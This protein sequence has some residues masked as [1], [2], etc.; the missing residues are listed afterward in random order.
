VATITLFPLDRIFHARNSTCHYIFRNLD[1]EP[2]RVPVSS[3]GFPVNRFAVVVGVL[4]AAFIFSC[5]SSSLTGLDIDNSYDPNK[6]YAWVYDDCG[7]S[8][9]VNWRYSPNHPGDVTKLVFDSVTVPAVRM[10][11]YVTKTDTALVTLKVGVALN[12]SAGRWELKERQAETIKADYYEVIYPILCPGIVAPK[13][14]TQP[15][16][17]TVDD[18]GLAVFHVEATD[19]TPAKSGYDYYGYYDSYDYNT[20]TWYVNGTEY[21]YAGPSF[22]YLAAYPG[23]HNAKVKVVV[24]NGYAKVT[25]RTVTLTVNATP[26]DLINL[27]T[28]LAYDFWYT[29]FGGGYYQVDT[30][31]A[32]ADSAWVKASVR[33]TGVTYQWYRN[34][35]LITGAGASLLSLGIPR[36]SD[37]GTVVKCV[38]TNPRGKDSATTVVRVKMPPWGTLTGFYAAPVNTS[39][40]SLLDFDTTSSYI[41]NSPGASVTASQERLD[42][43]VAQVGT[44]NFRLLT[45]KFARQL[46]VSS[47]SALDTA[48]LSGLK[49]VVTAVAP[50]TQEMAKALYDQGPAVDSVAINSGGSIRGNS[51]NRLILK[52]RA[53]R[54]VILQAGSNFLG[55][56][57]SPIYYFTG[58]SK[59]TI[60]D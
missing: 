40:G 3:E 53:G 26:P 44:G 38:I 57:S 56:S 22:A 30:L 7:D 31:T 48:R 24:N 12:V 19:G 4:L 34:G 16:N 18:G 32:G 17:V 58:T 37:S 9:R 13:I 29:Y 8:L 60:F 11:Q 43:V 10:R 52:T 15:E 2:I 42:L 23:D 14:T 1:A 49:M 47:V 45:P 28:V 39:Y 6:P 55:T 50:A 33:G 21:P 25:S 51:S 46:N 41:S 54:Y 5:N 35:S 20:Y 27:H 59:G 36:K